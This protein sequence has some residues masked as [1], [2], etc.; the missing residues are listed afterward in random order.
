MNEVEQKHIE[1]LEARIAALEAR[2]NDELPEVPWFV[3]AAA[4]AAV[5]PNARIIEIAAVIE[6]RATATLQNIW[7]V[8]GR[9]ELLGSHKLR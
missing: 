4:V 6:G 2:L 1:A 5:V 9:L 3:I 8:G 7:C